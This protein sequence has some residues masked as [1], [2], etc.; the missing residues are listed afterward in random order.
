MFRIM[1]AVLT[2]VL[3]GL[4]TS[5][6]YADIVIGVAGPMTGGSAAFGEEIKQGVELAVEEM[7]AHGGLL[8]QKIKLIVEDDACDPRQAL[9]VATK[10]VAEKAFAVI[11]H[12][13]AV[14]SMPASEIYAEEGILQLEPGALI[15]QLTHR[16]MPN[17][18]RVSGTTELFANA[19][20]SYIKQ[21]NAGKNIAIVTDHFAAPIELT[22]YLQGYFEHS[23]N[24]VVA[25][26][27]IG[28]EQKDFSST[29]D[30]LKAANAKIVICSCFTEEAGLLGRQMNEK[31]LDVDYYGWDTFTS[32]DF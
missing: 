14:A 10:M 7:N 15:V 6:A 23:S 25:V 19:M 8:G 11:G 24:P 31:K 26:E 21:H 20:S 17:L 22:K 12:W 28:D 2:V 3:V 13:C 4:P 27:E 18:F 30:K 29:I 9:N 5:P 16:N 32:P 1:I